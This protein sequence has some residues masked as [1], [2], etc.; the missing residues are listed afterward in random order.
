[1]QRALALA[2]R[3][4]GYV[5]PNPMVGCVIVKAGRVIAEG[6]HRR[7]GGPHAEVV[8]LR[9][10]GPAARGATVY[11][12]LE[13]CCHHGKTG[14]CTDSL[15]AAAVRRV[16]AAMP[17]P[18]PQVSR[19]GFGKLRR[20]GIEVAT[21]LCREQAERLNA[22]YLKRLH[23]GLPW[24]LLKW[25]QTIDGKLAAAGGQSKWITGQPARKQAHLLRGR[26]DAILIGVGT[27]LA[28]DPML[29]C[30]LVRPRR[31]ARRIVVD[32][33]LR[34]PANCKLVRTARQVPVVVA[35]ARSSARQRTRKVDMLRQAGCEVLAL[36][37][38]GPGRIDL[39]LLLQQLGSQ[40]ATNVMV[41]GGG[42]LLGQFLDRQLADELVA[43]V[44]GRLLGGTG[45]MVPWPKG[46]E[47]LSGSPRLD[48][49]SLRRIGADWL[50]RGLLRWP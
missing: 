23:T 3:G 31:I 20:A 10:A 22:P 47:K 45:S 11:V 12:T 26:V 42:D 50:L 25:A 28:D 1:M 35:C 7:F 46:V 29:T 32:G 34:L 18:A 4:R 41:E 8:A 27:V 40:G 30:R 9:K 39:R 13:P 43:F 48:T 15:V 6:Y 21:G 19:K 49:P 24:V 44:A 5:E 37:Q 17:D 36:P 16:V 2:G 33:R 14:P 38:I